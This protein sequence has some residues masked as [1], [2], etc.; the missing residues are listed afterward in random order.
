MRSQLR[1]TDACPT[2]AS[3]A[4]TV[5]AGPADVDADAPVPANVVA[6]TRYIN[7]APG[8]IAEEASTQTRID[9]H[10]S[11][12]TAPVTNGEVDDDVP[13]VVQVTPLSLLR[14]IR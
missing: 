9:E 4:D 2:I 1:L 7:D 10:V 3:S 8:V 12:V 11:P 14:S 6:L 13:I 5:F